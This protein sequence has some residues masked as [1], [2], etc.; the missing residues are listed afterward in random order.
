VEKEV[1]KCKCGQPT[2]IRKFKDGR[3][4]SMGV[5]R[6]CLSIR[7]KRRRKKD[8]KNPSKPIEKENFK[9]VIDFSNHPDILKRV[10]DKAKS[11]IRTIESQIIF[12]LKTI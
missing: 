9:I 1:P 12:F 11:E 7:N 6:D 4:N 2:I 8:P 3:Q 10:Q 5:C